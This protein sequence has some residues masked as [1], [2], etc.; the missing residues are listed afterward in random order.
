[1]CSLE[2]SLDG[3]QSFHLE[4]EIVSATN[5][6]LLL[7]LLLTAIERTVRDNVIYQ[8]KGLSACPS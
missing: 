3:T 6:G 7:L 5:Q 8:I 1:M 4:T 2:T